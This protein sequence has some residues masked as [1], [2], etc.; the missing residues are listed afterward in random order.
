MGRRTREMFVTYKNRLFF[1]H[2]SF[3]FFLFLVYFGK[4]SIVSLLKCRNHRLIKDKSTLF[5]LLKHFLFLF[6]NLK[7][8]KGP[9]KK[10]TKNFHFHSFVFKH[11]RTQTLFFSKKIV[12]SQKK[13]VFSQK[14]K[15]ILEKNNLKKEKVQLTVAFSRKQKRKKSKWF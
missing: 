3:S 11:Q 7:R 5:I 15:S 6:T 12:F 1:A 13:I 9:Q 4:I 8:A 14:K 10:K 2:S